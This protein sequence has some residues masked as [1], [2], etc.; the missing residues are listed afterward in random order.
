MW[1][2]P[3]Y[4]AAEMRAAEEAFEG[5]MLELMERAGAAAAAAALR[6]FADAERFT[7][8]CGTGA[9]GGDGFVVARILH[10]AGR[11]VE[12]VLAGAEEKVTGDAAANLAREIGRASCRERVL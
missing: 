6:R 4:T 11:A 8:W 1:T 7:V 2:E 3:L 9:N 12:V 10:E 5:T